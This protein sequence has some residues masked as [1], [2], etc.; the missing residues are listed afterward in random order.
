MEVA[1]RVDR[2]DIAG[3]EVA[4]LPRF[5]GGLGIFQILTEEPEARCLPGAPDEQLTRLAR[6]NVR[7]T[8]I[9]D[10]ILDARLCF[11]EACR[12]HFARLAVR[13]DHRARSSLRHRP[14]F[15]QWEAE[16]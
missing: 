3:V 6:P 4:V 16:P 7:A 11:A 14:G 5:S 10:S 13:N 1:F 15:E 8:L 2:H 9:H 12:T